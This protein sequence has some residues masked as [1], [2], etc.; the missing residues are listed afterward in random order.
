[1]SY[2]S[3]TDITVGSAVLRK[4][5]GLFGYNDGEECSLVFTSVIAVQ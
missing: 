2:K 3:D 1:M 4:D 5:D